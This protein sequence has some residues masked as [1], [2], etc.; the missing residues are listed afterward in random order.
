[1]AV[2]LNSNDCLLNVS[3]HFDVIPSVGKSDESNW[4][5]ASGEPL[6]TQL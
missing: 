4:N 5:V 1:M 2:H 6:D 3:I